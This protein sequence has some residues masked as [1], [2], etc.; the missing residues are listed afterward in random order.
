M[1]DFR[2][3][4]PPGAT[5]TNLK[6]AFGKVC[7][8]TSLVATM[9]FY[10]WGGTIAKAYYDQWQDNKSNV[11]QTQGWDYKNKTDD[12]PWAPAGG[13]L[14]LSFGLSA[15]AIAA[16]RRGRRDTYHRAAYND[17]DQSSYYYNSYSAS[18][19]WWF[20][21][22]MGRSSSGG[23]GWSSGSS[24]SSNDK[25]GAA[26]FFAAAIFIGLALSAGVVCAQGI[27]ENFGN[28]GP[29]PPG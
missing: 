12:L 13:S 11:A 21:Y 25:G 15:A 1:L 7:A 4:P 5:S 19:D 6:K 16:G 3:D 17:P 22:M 26:A 28:Q 23:G 2:R 14:A 18:N 9:G 20:W 8:I 24:S 29:K 10:I 27:K